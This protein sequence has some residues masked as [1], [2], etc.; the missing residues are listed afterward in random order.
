M[1]ETQHKLQEATL[2]EMADLVKMVINDGGERDAE[3]GRRPPKGRPVDV[4]EPGGQRGHEA[5]Q[6]VRR[7]RR[8]QEHRRG[9]L[10]KDSAANA[11][12]HM[13][14]PERIRKAMEPVLRRRASRKRWKKRRTRTNAAAAE[15]LYK[16]FEPTLK[17]GELD[18]GINLRGPSAKGL[19]AMVMAL[20]VKDGAAIDKTL[21]DLIPTL[22]E[23]DRANITLDFAKVGNVSIHKVEGGELDE[24][25]KEAF[26]DGPVYFAIRDDA[27]MVSLGDGALG[28]AE[29]RA[30]RQTGGEQGDPVRSLG[31]PADEAGSQGAAE[32]RRRRRPRRRS[33]RTR[34]PTRSRSCWRAGNV[35]ETA[36]PH[37]GGPGDVLRLPGGA[38]GED[39][40]RRRTCRDTTTG[41]KQ[42]RC[43]CFRP[44][45]AV[46]GCYG[47]D[48]PR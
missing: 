35:A 37:E 8:G 42:R 11:L 14:L 13:S 6:D 46:S 20:K 34:T 15:K 28:G 38:S 44:V 30:G 23:K 18:M 48:S 7:P 36:L 27:V 43:L 29:G 3:H 31:E 45:A 2:D 5:G 32:D 26:G 47:R 16:V 10:G 40:L 9:L 33:P 12:F 25:A 19:Y 39:R 17:S 24:K 21:K 4:A 22:P 1:T 41:L